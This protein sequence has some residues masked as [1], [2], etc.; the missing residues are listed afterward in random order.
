M[1][2]SWP[3]SCKRL[4]TRSNG[5]TSSCRETVSREEDWLS[6]LR[7]MRFSRRRRM[8]RLI[9]KPTSKAS[10]GHTNQPT[11]MSI[12]GISNTSRMWWLDASA[13]RGWPR[14]F[15]RRKRG[16][17]EAALG[18]RHATLP[19]FGPIDHKHLDLR[20][21]LWRWTYNRTHGSVY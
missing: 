20:P 3:G 16:S 17:I 4:F 21:V 1:E 2:K 12:G 11:L 15:H 6:R 8:G 13:T 10:R 5:N 18:C 9:G 7:R 19:V 14:M